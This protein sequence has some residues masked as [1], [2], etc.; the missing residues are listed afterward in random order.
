MTVIAP[1][2]VRQMAL[3]FFNPNG[4]TFLQHTPF[5]VLDVVSSSS[6]RAIFTRLYTLDFSKP[7]CEKR[8]SHIHS[9][10]VSLHQVLI[11]PHK[12]SARLVSTLV[13]DE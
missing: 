4:I 12:C 6:P 8:I 1:Y 5:I 11:P 3:T 2:L 9:A 7:I 13:W 10:C